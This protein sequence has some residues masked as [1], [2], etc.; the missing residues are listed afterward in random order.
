M[1]FISSEQKS[2]KRKEDMAKRYQSEKLIRNLTTNGF[3][4]GNA[5][6]LGFFLYHQATGVPMQLECGHFLRTTTQEFEQT[7]VCLLGQGGGEEGTLAHLIGVLRTE[8]AEVFKMKEADLTKIILK[9]QW[10]SAMAKIDCRPARPPAAFPDLQPFF[11][12]GGASVW[13]VGLRPWTWRFGPSDWPMPGLP[14]TV[15]ALTRPLAVQVFDIAAML[16]EGLA[17][18]DLRSYLETPSGGEF[19]KER[20][21]L[22][23]LEPG[24]SVFIPCGYLPVATVASGKDEEPLDEFRHIQERLFLCVFWRPLAPHTFL[25]GVWAVCLQGGSRE[26]CRFGRALRRHWVVP[27]QMRLDYCYVLGHVCREEVP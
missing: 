23:L 12:D 26:H 22:T 21:V 14:H 19:M 2:G 7:C 24:C 16:E 9:K 20:S 3:P 13:I 4:K 1:E 11:D 5:Q 15:T 8:Y 18:V 17:V 10:K 27:A 6:R 25:A